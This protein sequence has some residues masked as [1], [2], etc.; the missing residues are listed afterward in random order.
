MDASGWVALMREAEGGEMGSRISVGGGI[1]LL[2]I[3]N[4][5][6]SFNGFINYSIVQVVLI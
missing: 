2:R 4:V 1:L 5:D 6:D 3:S